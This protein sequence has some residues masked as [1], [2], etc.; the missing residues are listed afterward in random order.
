MNLI[1]TSVRKNYIAS[2]GVN[3][4]GT[5]YTSGKFGFSMDSL[6]ITS[7]NL[8]TARDVIGMLD[9]HAGVIQ[10][11][12]CTKDIFGECHRTQAPVCEL[13]DNCAPNKALDYDAVEYWCGGG[14]LGEFYGAQEI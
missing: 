10:T 2:Y 5:L 12:K 11:V 14:Y 13:L 7:T 9:S 1:G 6:Q 8:L 4:P 3:S